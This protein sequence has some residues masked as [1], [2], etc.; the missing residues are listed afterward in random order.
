MTPEETEWVRECNQ[1]AAAMAE[2][3]RAEAEHLMARLAGLDHLVR[4]HAPPRV[5]SAYRLL[6][7]AELASPL[8]RRV[9]ELEE[10]RFDWRAPREG[11]PVD[12]IRPVALEIRAADAFLRRIRPKDV[13]TDPNQEWRVERDEPV[14]VIPYE[15]DRV[16]RMADGQPYERR[17]FRFHRL[18]PCRA[19]G[20][21]VRLV[22]PATAYV[23][24]KTFRPRGGAAL[25]CD[26]DLQV[27]RPTQG[28]FQVRSCLAPDHEAQIAE[29]IAQARQA[30]CDLLV[31]PELTI[32]PGHRS[33]IR[34][35]LA[36]HLVETDAAAAMWLVVAGSCH[37]VQAGD[38][39]NRS[40]VFD[41]FGEL[42]LSFD[43]LQAYAERE[44][45]TEDIR[46]SRTVTVLLL[47]GRLV[48]F[49]ICRDFCDA[50]P[51]NPFP[52][53]DLD[54]FLVPSMGSARTA[55]GHLDTARLVR[56]RFD[57]R[58]FVVQQSDPGAPQQ[59]GFV[60]PPAS[61]LDS[62]TAADLV[63]T[64]AFGLYPG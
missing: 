64:T 57:A 59:L 60:V 41:G 2:G 47:E 25:F 22:A 16:G 24:A 32:S 12:L 13:P 48:G 56:T 14:L 1:A 54:Y 21:E 30:G 29:H 46:E 51:T 11:D 36:N 9:G 44:L 3:A 52:G 26:L 17:G 45:G 39:V 33:V 50:Y 31:W 19:S 10:E 15:A 43:K 42:L 18:L 40:V 34:A 62:L 38:V 49:G 53:L 23:R 55:S 61:D 4:H 35:S 37:E 6:T 20:Y 58:S 28:R 7:E 8:E 63:Q 5:R 27:D